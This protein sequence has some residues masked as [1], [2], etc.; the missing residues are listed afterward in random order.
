MENPVGRD[1]E[2][3][4]PFASGFPRTPAVDALLDAFARGDYA[5]VRSEGR[6]LSGSAPEEDVRGA[7]RTLVERTTPD[8]LAIWL[9]LLAGGLLL[10]LSA[11]WI[12]HGKA[13]SGSAPNA[14]RE[15]SAAER[16]R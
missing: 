15:Q 6:K 12:V 9:L 14:P 2:S 7:A 10:T 5:F 13:P 3:R 1:S 8:P 16:T 11:Y 4:K